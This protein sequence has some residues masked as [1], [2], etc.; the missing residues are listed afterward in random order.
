MLKGQTVNMGKNLHTEK[1]CG[2]DV[3]ILDVRI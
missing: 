3:R 2:D 1:R